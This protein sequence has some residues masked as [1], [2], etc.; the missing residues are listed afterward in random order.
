MDD[1]ESREDIPRISIDSLRDWR[2]VKA[3]I[4]NAVLEQFDQAIC[5]NER[6][7]LSSNTFNRCQLIVPSNSAS[8]HTS[9]QFIATTFEKAKLNVR[10]DGKKFED[11]KDEDDGTLSQ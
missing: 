1:T 5:Q 8:P 6:R 2:T 7:P 4:S 3:E 10:I 11:L 9:S